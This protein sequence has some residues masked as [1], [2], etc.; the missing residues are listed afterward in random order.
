MVGRVTRNPI[1]QGIRV[2]NDRMSKRV[3]KTGRRKSIK[4]L[5]EE[6]LE[7]KC[8]HLAFIDSKRFDRVIRLLEDRNAKYRRNGRHE[9][10]TRRNVPPKRTRFPGQVIECGI[11][12]YGYVF[13][14]HGQTDHLMCDGARRYCCWNGVT[15]GGPLTAEIITAA[16]LSEIESM[17]GFDQVFLEMVNEEANR[18]DADAAARRLESVDSAMCLRKNGGTWP[19]NVLEPDHCGG[20]HQHGIAASLSVAARAL[21]VN[22]AQPC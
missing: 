11:C 9:D 3:N 22:A 10:D 19:A 17:P 6:R 12:G 18:L 16:V 2:R 1:L 4:T 5:A 7:R 21:L 13:G 14:G 15:V 8:P 20:D